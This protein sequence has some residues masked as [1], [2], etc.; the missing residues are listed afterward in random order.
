MS[1][2]TD[3]LQHLIR[4]KKYGKEKE[5]EQRMLTATAEIIL[6]DF[7]DIALRG[8]ENSKETGVL[9]INLLNDSTV[10]MTGSDIEKD[11][12][13]ASRSEDEEVKDFLQ[14]LIKL[15]DKNDW[16]KN[17]LITLISDEGT[18]TFAIEA[19]RSQESLRAIAAELTG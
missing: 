7:I 6:S 8:L 1:R 17:V 15:V 18:R 16:S 4:S 5:Q 14:P 2:R 12:Q 11:L 9:I 3:L 19:G 13:E 10:F